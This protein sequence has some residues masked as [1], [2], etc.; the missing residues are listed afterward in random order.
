[1]TDQGEPL[2]ILADIIATG[3]NDVYVVK[4]AERE[5]L[6]PALE[7]VVREI[8]LAGGIMTVSPLEGLLDL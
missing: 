8:D 3:S 7:D 1:M 4:S 2:G 6:I 5:Y